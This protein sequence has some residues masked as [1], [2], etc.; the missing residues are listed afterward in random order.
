M[1]DW[2]IFLCYSSW[3]NEESRPPPCLWELSVCSSYRMFYMPGSEVRAPDGRPG[4]HFPLPHSNDISSS[5]TCLSDKSGR[6]LSGTTRSQPVSPVWCHQIPIEERKP[7]LIQ[8][9]EF[10][11]Q[12]ERYHNHH[13][14]HSW[15]LPDSCEHVLEPFLY[16]S[17][18]QSPL[19][20]NI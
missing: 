10:Q 20:I 5:Q 16:C 1:M 8:I 13:S 12:V 2:M 3:L 6:H 14:C 18:G 9:W 4:Y 19:K 15:L 7:M 11:A 17:S